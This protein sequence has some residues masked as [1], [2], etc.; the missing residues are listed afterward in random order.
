MA[1]LHGKIKEILLFLDNIHIETGTVSKEIKK[2]K[3]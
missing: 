1:D 2:N 3:T